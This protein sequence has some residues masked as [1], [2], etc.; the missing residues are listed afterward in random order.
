[1]RK[2]GIDIEN[3]VYTVKYAKEKILEYLK[4]GGKL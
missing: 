2:K 4:S 1:M 3:D